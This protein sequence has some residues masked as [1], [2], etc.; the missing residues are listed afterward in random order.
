MGSDPADQP[1]NCFGTADILIEGGI[2][3]EHLADALV[4]EVPQLG[5]DPLQR[6]AAHAIPVAGVEAEVAGKS[7]AARQL[8][9]NSRI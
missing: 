1:Q 7:T 5:L 3:H 8:P 9:E 4:N 6:E 2:K